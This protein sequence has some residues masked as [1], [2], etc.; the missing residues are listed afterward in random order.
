M[1]VA[2]HTLFATTPLVGRFKTATNREELIEK[3]KKLIEEYNL[4]IT[5][6]QLMREKAGDA[7]VRASFN[8]KK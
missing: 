4:I 6:L 1:N 3:E 2:R 8:F 7:S 5:N